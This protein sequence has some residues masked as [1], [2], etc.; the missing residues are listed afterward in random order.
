[1]SARNPLLARVHIAR[2]ELA[3]TEDSYRSVLQ[4]IT[5][6]ESAGKCSDEEL[7]RVLTEF[8]RLGWTPKLKRPASNVGHVRKI[9]AIWGDVK[10][11]LE[12]GSE[13]ALR[14]FC[15][16]QTGVEQPEWL[17]TAQATAVIHGLNGWLERLRKREDA[18]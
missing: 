6:H 3:L 2:K 1:M 5:G 7:D 15:K 4:R 16:R 17:T 8:R 10:P 12:D 11:L 13:A 18:A 9:Y 14:G